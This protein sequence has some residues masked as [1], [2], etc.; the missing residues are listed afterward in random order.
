MSLKS[1]NKRKAGKFSSYIICCHTVKYCGLFCTGT[2]KAFHIMIVNFRT[3]GP[4]DNIFIFYF[5]NSFIGCSSSNIQY[6]FV[7]QH[8]HTHTRPCLNCS[9]QKCQRR[10]QKQQEKSMEM[11]RNPSLEK[12]IINRITFETRLFKRNL[13]NSDKAHLFFSH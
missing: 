3:L 10:R 2:Y 1:Y 7:I 4:R 5:F 8:T 12:E 13:S 6:K 9:R 11:I